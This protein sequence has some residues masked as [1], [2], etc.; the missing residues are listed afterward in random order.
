MAIVDL[1]KKRKWES[2]NIGLEMDAHYFTAYSYKKLLDGLPDAKLIDSERL[3]NWV[4][5]VKSDA[6]I[7]LMKKASVITE[8]GMKK[9]FECIKPG[10]RQ[11]DAVS[12]ITGALI[13]GTKDFGGEYSSIVPLLPTGKGTSASHLTWSDAKFVE[14]E[15][16]IIEVSGVYKRYH[17]PMARTVLLGKPDQKKIDTM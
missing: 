1:I 14:G 3:V 11:N 10:V 4:R 2:L 8:I 16:T 13:R 5:V 6:E 17:C 15:A 7:D 12:E 9:A